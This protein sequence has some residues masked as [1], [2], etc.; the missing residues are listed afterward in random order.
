MNF[1]QKIFSEQ[2]RENPTTQQRSVTNIAVI[3]G[4]TEDLCQHNNNDPIQATS[5]YHT[6]Y[7]R[8]LHHRRRTNMHNMII[9]AT[10]VKV[11]NQLQSTVFIIATMGGTTILSPL[12]DDNFKEE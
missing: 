12:D 4:W 6:T 3:E 8:I 7:S 10:V 9:I 11:V 5:Y 2:K 1:G